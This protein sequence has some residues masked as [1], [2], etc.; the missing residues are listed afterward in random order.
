MSCM[1]YY[2]I[3]HQVF[4]YTQLNDESVLFQTIQFS[5]SDLFSLILNVKYKDH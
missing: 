2:T 4:T 5:R 3:K 1:T